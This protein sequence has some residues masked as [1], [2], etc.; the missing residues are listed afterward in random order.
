MTTIN[1]FQ[2][3]QDLQNAGIPVLGNYV[4]K[5]DL[6]RYL[7]EIEASVGS[8]ASKIVDCDCM[9]SEIIDPAH[10]TNASD[11]YYVGYEKLPECIKD[12]FEKVEPQVENSRYTV[13]E[14]VAYMRIAVRTKDDA[15]VDMEIHLGNISLVGDD[16]EDSLQDEDEAEERDLDEEM[17][18]QANEMK[19]NF[20]WRLQDVY[21]EV[22]QEPEEIKESFEDWKKNVDKYTQDILG[23]TPDDISGDYRWRHLYDEGFTTEEAYTSWKEDLDEP[24]YRKVV[25]IE[26]GE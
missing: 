11:T 16:D 1:K 24:T 4:F 18:E 20:D 14:D 15:E 19:S 6:K 17:A 23:M 21:F 5:K 12:L 25:E 10:K 9:F 7:N 22:I 3:K 2:L 8:P 13:G 26:K